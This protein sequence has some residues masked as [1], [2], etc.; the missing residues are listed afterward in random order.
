MPLTEFPHAPPPYPEQECE[1]PEFPP[2]EHGRTVR[3]VRKLVVEAIKNRLLNG[4]D[5]EDV[6]TWIDSFSPHD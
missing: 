6:K 4:Q 5:A 1:H 3:L 2:V